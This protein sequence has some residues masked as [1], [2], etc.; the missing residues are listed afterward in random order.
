MREVPLRD[1]KAGFSAVVDQAAKGEATVVTRH[2][3]PV[4]VVLGFPEGAPPVRDPRAARDPG[5]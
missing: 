2:G 3:T 4:A 1:A 5:L